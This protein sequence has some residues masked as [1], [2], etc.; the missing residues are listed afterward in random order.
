MPRLRRRLDAVAL[1]LILLGGLLAVAVFSSRPIT[2]RDNLLGPAGEL[3]ARVVVDAVGYAASLFLL[4]WFGCVALYVVRRTWVR[5]TV[6]G[7]G[8]LLITACGT[9]A[10]DWT[11]GRWAL[12]Q[13]SAYG[14][15]GSIGAWLRLWLDAQLPAPLPAV[16][17]I[18]VTFVGLLMTMDGVL[19]AIGRGLWHLLHRLAMGAKKGNDLVAVGGERVLSGLGAFGKRIASARPSNTSDSRYRASRPF[20]S[21]SMRSA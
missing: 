17:L 8:W 7:L 9:V 19:R 16:T 13:L 20:T 11:V 5:L 15:G 2:A 21:A 3:L 12:P 10:A 18:A 1:G 4:G 6:R 14:P